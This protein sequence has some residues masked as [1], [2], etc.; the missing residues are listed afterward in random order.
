MSKAYVFAK[1]VDSITLHCNRWV[2]GEAPPHT[3]PLPPTPC[4]PLGPLMLPLGG[5]FWTRPVMVGVGTCNFTHVHKVSGGLPLPRPT[6]LCWG[7]PAPQP[8]VWGAGAPQNQAEGFRVGSPSDSM[9]KIAM[10]YGGDSEAPLVSPVLAT[11]QTCW[12]T[13]VGG[14]CDLPNQ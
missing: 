1:S 9:C 8:G 5:A 13:G 10:P 6:G 11:E 2:R 14:G 7:A 4:P 12:E 3:H